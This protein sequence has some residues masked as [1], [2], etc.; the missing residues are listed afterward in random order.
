MIQK[1]YKKGIIQVA[2]SIG[3]IV[4][5]VFIMGSTYNGHYKNLGTCICIILSIISTV[6]CLFG[7][8]D[9]LKA[10]GYDTSIMLAFLIPGICCS[11]VFIML[12]PLVIIYGMKD[13]TKPHR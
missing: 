3:L 7:C 10:K 9:L 8:S 12:A 6:I 11:A 1:Y 5:G 2:V 13:R 4:C